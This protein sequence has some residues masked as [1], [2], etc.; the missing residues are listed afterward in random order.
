MNTIPSLGPDASI[1]PRTG[2]AS[3]QTPAQQRADTAPAVIADSAAGADPGVLLKITP[4]VQSRQGDPSVM[5]DAGGLPSTEALAQALARDLTGPIAS[6]G[7]QADLAIAKRISE[8]FAALP[9]EVQEAIKQASTP[10]IAHL[11][12]LAAMTAP[13]IRDAPAHILDS[14]GPL[15]EQPEQAAQKLHQILRDAPPFQLAR[16]MREAL[17][18]D[19]SAQGALMRSMLQQMTAMRASVAATYGGAA[20]ATS[21][22]AAGAT[23]GEDSGN[24]KGAVQSSGAQAA[25]AAQAGGLSQVLD[26]L[27][28][29][30]GDAPSASFQSIGP[31]ASSRD[32]AGG[33]SAGQRGADGANTAN[34]QGTAFGRGALVAQQGNPASGSAL[35]TPAADEASALQQSGPGTGATPAQAVQGLASAAG[36]GEF[37]DSAAM[38]N[39]SMLLSPQQGAQALRDGLKILMDG[40]LI[41]HGQFTPGVPMA[42]E[43]SDAWRADRDAVGGMQKGTALRFRL[44]LPQ[45][46]EIEIRAVG[47]GGQVSARVHA[48]PAVASTLAQALPD[49]EARLRAH[50]LAGAHVAVEPH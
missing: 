3:P 2:S 43:R 32:G 20:G 24:G 28:G 49:L 44:S 40:R 18:A 8:A 42:M 26:L 35:M 33:L 41:W 7:E 10:A 25:A 47:F 27:M 38:N 31:L 6:S 30:A 12:R 15:A 34:G 19:P 46:G 5:G 21:G 39:A 48:H 23:S 22:G 9:V 4:P 11:L 1:S 16:L 13:G 17:V 37:S 36:H 29:E 14:P 50:G 45:L